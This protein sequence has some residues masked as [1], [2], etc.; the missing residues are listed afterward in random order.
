MPAQANMRRLSMGAVIVIAMITVLLPLCM[1]LDCGMGSGG[2]HHSSMLGF[3]SDCASAMTVVAQAAVAP[4][5]PQSLILLLVAAFGGALAFA[6]PPLTTR[7]VRVAAED[8]PPPPEDP[9]GV[10]LII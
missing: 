10:R 6:A 1:A 5:S 4:G 3:S 7:L 8:P 9:R 2:M